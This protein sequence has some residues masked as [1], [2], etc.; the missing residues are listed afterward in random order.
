MHRDAIAEQLERA[1]RV[2]LHAPELRLIALEG[3]RPAIDELREPWIPVKYGPASADDWFGVVPASAKFE[4]VRGGASQSLELIVKVNPREGLARNLIPWIIENKGIVLDRPYPEYRTTA[5][6]DHTG[7]RETHLYRLAETT[8]ALRNVL[9]R[10]YGFGSDARSGEHALFLELLNAVDRLDSTG[11]SADW[12]A[13]AL[14]EALRAAA[15]WHAAFWDIAGDQMTWAGPRPTTAHMIADAPLWHGLLDDARRRF[16]DIVNAAVWR[17]RHT[18]IE[19][20]PAW[21]AIKDRLPATLVHDDFNQR[22]VG[23]RRDNGRARIVVLDWELAQRNTAQ[24][25]LVEMLTFALM[26]EVCRAEVDGHVE[27]HRRSLLDAGVNTGVDHDA[28]IEG[29]RCELKLEAINRVAHQLLF[30]AE[31]P[32]T[33]LGRINATIE[34]LLDLYG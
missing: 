21:H 7:A 10:C 1:L 31:F 14:D 22:N 30:A 2:S 24:R 17:R 27:A 26:P 13:P 8:P 29:F 23:F 6:M 15:G 5:E 3:A 20:L 4:R 28:W 34:R 32:L 16:P 9:P 33:Y 12:P 18:L 11:A 19:T 25:D